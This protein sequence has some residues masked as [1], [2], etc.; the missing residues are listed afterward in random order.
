[1]TLQL[2]G[3]IKQSSLANLQVRLPA[4]VIG[5]GLT[6]IDTATEVQAYYVTQVEKIHQRYHLLKASCSTKHL[7]SHFD[8]QSLIILDE[9]LAHA[10]CIIAER[11]QAQQENRAPHLNRLIRQWGGVTI[12]YRKSIQESP[13]YQRNH[14][15]MIKALEEG[16]YYAEGLAPVSVV[17]DT[18]GA[19]EA[20]LCRSRIQ[21]EYG[22]WIWSDEQQALP[23]KSIF[24]AT[25]AKPNIAYEFEHRG[26]FARANTVYETYEADHSLQNVLN[27]DHV[28]SDNIGMFTS[29]DRDDRRV[30]FMGDTHPVFHGSIVKAIASAKQGYPKIMRVLKPIQN[31]TESYTQFREKISDLFLSRIVSIERHTKNVIALTVHSKMAAHQF[32]PGQFYRLQNYESL[33]PMVNGSRL[34]TEAIATLGIFNPSHPDQLSFFVIENGASTK[35]VSIGWRLF[36]YYP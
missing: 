22:Q 20:I 1:M 10:E 34:Q 8:A 28:K 15:E 31:T 35:L 12:A 7:R 29:Y 11:A 21:D 26:T 17:L 4:V 27:S 9:F 30:S 24:V 25:G 18:Y 13:A 2:T 23:A 5:G 14:E 3:A 6:G 36:T 33:A 16:I 19:C 32:K